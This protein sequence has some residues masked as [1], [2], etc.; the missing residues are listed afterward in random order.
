MNWERALPISRAARSAPFLWPRTREA[1]P[2]PQQKVGEQRAGVGSADTDYLARGGPSAHASLLGSLNPTPRCLCRCGFVTTLRGAG[3]VKQGFREGLLPRGL[4]RGRRVALPS[5]RAAAS[6]VL[7][8]STGHLARSLLRS[9]TLAARPF[10]SAS[11]CCEFT[12]LRSRS[13]TAPVS[14]AAQPWTQVLIKF[15]INLRQYIFG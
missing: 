8:P 5:P 12:S 13:K 14:L 15:I 9:G 4:R 7:G 3:G 10:A 1:V 6:P 2:V 11:L